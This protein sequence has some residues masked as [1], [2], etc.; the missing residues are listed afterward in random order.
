MVD[1]FYGRLTARSQEVQDKY[2]THQASLRLEFGDDA[3]CPFCNLENRKIVEDGGEMLVL[4]NDFPYEVYDGRGVKEH[5]MIVPKRHVANF[6][7]FT[8]QELEAYWLLQSK[9]HIMG[10]S[11]MT[12]SAID[13]ERSVPTHLHTHLFSYFTDES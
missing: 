12:R 1:E 7:D 6:E 3:P 11:S 13:V 10:Y 4:R 9:Y 2:D 5:L 8:G